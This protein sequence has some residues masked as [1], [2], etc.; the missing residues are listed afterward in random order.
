MVGPGMDVA[1]PD[2]GLRVVE[3]TKSV[4]LQNGMGFEAFPTNEP[5]KKMLDSL[6]SAGDQAKNLSYVTL[7]ESFFQFASISCVVD[8]ASSPISGSRTSGEV[9]YIY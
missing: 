6:T 9:H 3:N 5:L 1:S 8:F 2:T 4:R 7:G